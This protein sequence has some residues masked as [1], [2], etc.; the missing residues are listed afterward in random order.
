MRPWDIYSSLPRPAHKGAYS[1]ESSGCAYRVARS[2]EDFPALI[3]EFRHP[4]SSTPRRLSNLA[5]IPPSSVD[6]VGADGSISSDYLAVLECRSVDT[7]LGQY[8]FR[9]TQAILTGNESAASEAGFERA[10]DTLVRLF[11]ALRRPATRSLQGLW[12]ELAIIYWSKN[13]Q[14]AISSWHSTPAALHDF[15]SGNTRFEVK[16]TQK[17]LREH[18]FRLDQLTASQA[19]NTLIASLLL[20]EGPSGESVRGLSDLIASR[21][22]G[23]SESAARLEAIIAESLGADWKASDDV[24]FLLDEALKSFRIYKAT[25]VPTVP[26]PLPVEVKEVHFLSDLSGLPPLNFSRART[27]APLYDDLLPNP[28]P[29]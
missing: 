15:S 23:S 16:S 6:V 7:D 9:I 10:L 14:V 27:F 17:P 22:E 28:D 1:V 19:G 5:Y 12:A 20:K 2:A 3:I 24:R 18:H 29:Y 8:F 26:E 21:L 25:D 4:A 11:H 13:P